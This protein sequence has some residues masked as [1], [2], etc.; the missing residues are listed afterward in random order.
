M[1]LSYIKC[2][3]SGNEFVMVDAVG[4]ELQGVDL[5]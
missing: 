5:A 1:K 2:H 4:V 3:G